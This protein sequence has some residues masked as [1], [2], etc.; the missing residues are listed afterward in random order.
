LIAPWAV[1]GVAPEPPEANGLPRTVN[2]AA[3]ETKQ[4]ITRPTRLLLP[5]CEYA[6]RRGRRSPR[7]TAPAKP[8]RSGPPRGDPVLALK[9]Q[10]IIAQ[11]RATASPWVLVLTGG[12]RSPA[13]GR[14]NTDSGRPGRNGG[15]GTRRRCCRLANTRTAKLGRSP[16]DMMMI[17]AKMAPRNGPPRFLAGLGVR[18]AGPNAIVLRWRHAVLRAL[19]EGSRPLPR[20]RGTQ[21]RT[22]Q[23]GTRAGTRGQG[24]GIA[25]GHR[26]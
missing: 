14:F 3:P 11:G 8:A 21:A 9:G 15:S 16:R 7:G 5:T 2:R 26:L 25:D 1:D 17:G 10:R 6:H 19:A 20:E 22:G 13:R 23:G 24:E 18:A 4:G 12:K